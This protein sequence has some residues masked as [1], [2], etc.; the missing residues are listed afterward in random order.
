MRGE[1]EEKSI[2][3]HQTKEVDRTKIDVLVWSDD[4]LQHV[5]KSFCNHSF[6]FD[7]N[8]DVSMLEKKNKDY[9]SISGFPITKNIKYAND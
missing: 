3:K 6:S 5:S 2:K 1:E 4:H 8:I 7:S 9:Q